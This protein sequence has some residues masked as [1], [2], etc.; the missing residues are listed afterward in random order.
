MNKILSWLV[1]IGGTFAF[2]LLALSQYNDSAS[3]RLYAQSAII[4]ANSSAR[5]D[6]LAAM[7][8]YSVL[9]LGLIAMVMVTGLVLIVIIHMTKQCNL[10]SRRPYTIER[11]FVYLLPNKSNNVDGLQMSRRQVLQQVSDNRDIIITEGE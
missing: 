2:I 6:L 5:Q 1:V 4:Q 9:A 3:K 11:H 7:L 8:P 10:P